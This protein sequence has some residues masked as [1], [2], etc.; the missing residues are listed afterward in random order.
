M[1]SDTSR[2]VASLPRSLEDITP[3]WLGNV[4]QASGH[5]LGVIDAEP[6]G[7][8]WGSASK[9]FARAV[10]DT[11]DKLDLCIKGV[12]DEPRQPVRIFATR[13]E[14]CF[15][16]DLAPT[17]DVPMFNT[18]VTLADDDQGIVIFDDLRESGIEFTEVSDTW[19]SDLVARALEV[20]ARWHAATWDISTER[21]GWLSRG[22]QALA[23]AADQ[24]FAADHWD[25]HLADPTTVSVPDSLAD[26]EAVSAGIR[27]LFDL[28]DKRLHALSH[29]D[30]HIGN[31]YLDAT[32]QPGFYDWQ[33]V[34][35]APPL[36]DVTYFIGGALTVADRRAH[37]RDLLNHYLSALRAAGGPVLDPEDAWEDYRRTH[38]HGFFWAVLPTAWQPVTVSVPLA[39]RYLAAISD[40]D[41]LALLND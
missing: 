41:S 25:A 35:T 4:L 5:R 1:S 7:A 24:L 14:A 31:T 32:G 2:P 9:V 37:E 38:F 34:C 16:R 6:N 28:Q 17:M 23:L 15:F 29:G 40:H 26:R 3:T 13:Q 20:Q 10:L 27:R 12:F 30:A 39:E 36:D 11:G 19:S 33:T 8:I 22:S 18:W 21:Y